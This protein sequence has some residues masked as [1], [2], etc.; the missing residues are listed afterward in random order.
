MEF[1]L[2]MTILKSKMGHL[3]SKIRVIKNIGNVKLSSY[4]FHKL[5]NKKK[6]EK[7]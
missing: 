6:S 3:S 7:S 2:L 1:I 4:L 5:S